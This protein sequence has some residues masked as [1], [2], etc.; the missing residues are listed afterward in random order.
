MFGEQNDLAAV[1]AVVRD[2]TVDG[3]HHGVRFAANGDGAH[4][5][6]IGERFERGE[7]A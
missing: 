3:L 2:L 7:K 5:V 6:G 1:V 4:E